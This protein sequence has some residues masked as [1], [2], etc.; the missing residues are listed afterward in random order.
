LLVCFVIVSYDVGLLVLICWLG[1]WFN[2]GIWIAGLFFYFGNPNPEFVLY[3][4]SAAPYC[5]LLFN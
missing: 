4:D 1:C 3:F 2:A 5:G